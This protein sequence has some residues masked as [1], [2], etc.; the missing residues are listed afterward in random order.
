MMRERIVRNTCPRN[1]LGGCSMLSYI[2][3]NQLVKVTGDRLQKFNHGTLCA[4]G[5]AYTQ[6]VYH[7]ARIKFP[8]KQVPRGSGNWQRISWDEALE[9]I[10][11]KMIELKTRYGSNLACCYNKDYGNRGL[12]HHATE[13]MFNSIGPH[14]KTLGDLCGRSGIMAIKNS[15][16][17]AFSGVPEKMA[18]SK[19][20]VVWGSN[21]AVTNVQQMR[22]IHQ[23][24]QSGAI[25]VC[26]DPIFTQT[27]KKADLFIQIQPGSDALLAMGIMKLLNQ[28]GDLDQEFIDHYTTGWKAYKTRLAQTSFAEICLHTGL[29]MEVL[30]KLYQL[31]TQHTPV[32]TL[33]GIGVQRNENG[34]QAVNAILSLVAM[35]GNLLA[36]HGGIYYFHD[37]A[38][39]FPRKLL[40]HPYPETSTSEASRTIDISRF[41][42]SALSLEDPPLRL[43]WVACRNP[44][45]Q[46]ENL[47][48]WT[49]LLQQMELIV[50]V[51]LFLTKTAEAS[52]IVL[53]AASHFEE[54]DLHVS[55][56]H[57]WL[58]LN[59]KAIAPYFEAKSD[60]QIA[61]DLTKKLNELVPHFS[62]FPWEKEALDWIEE[63]CTPEMLARYGLNSM[64]DLF[65]GPHHR[66]DD[67]NR[68]EAKQFQF[69]LDAHE[70][71]HF[72]QEPNQFRIL[73]PQSLLRIHSQFEQ[74]DWLK[75]ADESLVQIPA[76]FAAEQGL[77]HEDFVKLSNQHGS[78]VVQVKLNQHLPNNVLL[79]TQNGL[80]SINQLYVQEIH[81]PS[82]SSTLFNDC[83]VHLEKISPMDLHKNE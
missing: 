3:D 81:P 14:T 34:R 52:D 7:P 23:A 25:L 27:A 43:L 16:G 28:N 66:V 11:T 53:P 35:S 12:L 68:L 36:E 33:C 77:H 82:E 55:W 17:S 38:C 69:V 39:D 63:E 30:Q 59:Q 49:A 46:D 75:I 64:D 76:Q 37:A 54:E 21:P 29:S 67:F 32:S 41:V 6:F 79:A 60:L 24:R 73:T 42:L 15:I 4:K 61:R 47:H 1:C 26:I 40:N 19:L 70:Q 51:D 56:W 72:V 65:S 5:Y 71:L 74:L 58:S 2:A 18:G 57:H 78:V 62:N 80:H 8:M 44:L 50:T 48:A 10:A 45:S 22:F 13:G 9:T 31:Y 20:I 83:I